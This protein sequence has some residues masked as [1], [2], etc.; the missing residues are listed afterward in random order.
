MYRMKQ[1]LGGSLTLRYIPHNSAPLDK[2]R[3][4]VPKLEHRLCRFDVMLGR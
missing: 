4:K 2:F 1:L 3:R